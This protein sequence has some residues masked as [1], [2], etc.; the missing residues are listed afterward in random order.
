MNMKSKA[1]VVGIVLL[2]SFALLAAAF[3]GPAVGENSLDLKSSSPKD[4]CKVKTYAGS[5]LQR[6]YESPMFALFE[7]TKSQTKFETSDIIRA[8]GN[9]YAICDSSWAISKLSMSLPNYSPENVQIG[10]PLQSLDGDTED[11]GFEGIFAPPPVDAS[12]N[13]LPA[14]DPSKDPLY[15]VRESIDTSG[16][17]DSSD[18]GDSDS[19]DREYHAVVEKVFLNATDPNVGYS[20][21]ESCPTVYQFEGDSKGLEGATMVRGVDGAEYILGLCEG[22]YC[23]EGD[24]GKDRGN[25]RV[26]VLK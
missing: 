19:A 2:G 20:V 23:A 13:F 1:I 21:Q 18:S 17:T 25:G 5:V 10:N 26:I 9:L 7:D 24:K 14:W 16:G 12:G 15:V 6:A 8:G 22:N 4:I 3:N 11:S